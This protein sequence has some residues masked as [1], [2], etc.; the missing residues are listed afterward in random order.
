[1]TELHESRGRSNT[2]ENSDLLGQLDVSGG[3]GNK[4]A[5]ERE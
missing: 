5:S 4:V 2:F 3:V 1:V